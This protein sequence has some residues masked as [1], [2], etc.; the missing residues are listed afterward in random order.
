MANGPKLN[1]HFAAS[2]ADTFEWQC[3]YM[4][5]GTVRILGFVNAISDKQG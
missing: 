3:R 4:E 5:G 2:R 1:A